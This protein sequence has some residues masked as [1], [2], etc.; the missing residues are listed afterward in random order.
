MFSL[1]QNNVFGKRVN[2]ML[3]E[4]G[5]ENGFFERIF[6]EL[7]SCVQCEYT[8]NMLPAMSIESPVFCCFLIQQCAIHRQ[9]LFDGTTFNSPLHSPLDCYLVTPTSMFTLLF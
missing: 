2:A 3:F 4:N 8:E 5:D 9:Q 1:I 7:Y 6:V